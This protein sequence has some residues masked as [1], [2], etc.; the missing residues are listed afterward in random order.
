MN[1]TFGIRNSKV[2]CVIFYSSFS[3]VCNAIQTSY[4]IILID[5]VVFT[6]LIHD[7]REEKKTLGIIVLFQREA[8]INL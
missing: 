3:F 1:K 2:F 5:K 6:D 4:C 8:K 7:Y